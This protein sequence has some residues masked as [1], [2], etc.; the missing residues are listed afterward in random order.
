M[1]RFY[2]LIFLSVFSGGIFTKA[3]AQATAS[4]PVVLVDFDTETTVDNTILITWTT[5]QQ[6]N[7]DCFEIEKSND[8]MS[9]QRIAKIPS[10][11]N[12]AN[13]VSYQMKD[14]FPLKGVNYYRLCIR[15]L[16]GAFGYTKVRSA[17]MNILHNTIVY[18]NP[19]ADLVTVLL[20]KIPRADWQLTLYNSTGQVVIQRRFARTTTTARLVVSNFI[21]GTY[22]LETNDGF[23]KTSN[24]LMI[25]HR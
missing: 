15:D 10:T 21:N 11:G 6:I 13:P 5:R 17:R 8:A 1:R 3:M 22:T 24:K 14:L 25:N 9:W 16:N 12:S 4:L 19:S 7:T 2:M 23:S 20:P 18:P